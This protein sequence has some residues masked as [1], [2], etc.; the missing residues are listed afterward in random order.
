MRLYHVTTWDKEY[1]IVLKPKVPEESLASENI[2]IE[3]ISFSTS[4]KGCLFGLGQSDRF[5]DGDRIR[6]YEINVNAND[7]AL[8]SPEKLYYEGLVDDALLSNEYWYLK[9][10]LPDRYY[11]YEI[12]NI[13]IDKYIVY[14][15]TEETIIK[16]FLE[17]EK[18]DYH[19]AENL[20][21][22]VNFSI[23]KKY[24]EKM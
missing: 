5:F 24:K 11:E 19:N 10:I 22:L 1:Q 12:S 17:N 9:A 14:P 21:S 2:D 16:T 20:I 18:I 6:V 3:R 7:E 13:S 15:V 4:I 23:G 8:Y